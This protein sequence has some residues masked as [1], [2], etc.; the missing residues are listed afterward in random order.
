MKKIAVLAL[1]DVVPFDL[2]IPCGVFQFAYLK[3]GAPAYEV[4]VCGPKRSVRSKPFDLRIS[5]GLA[6]LRDADT[7]LVP[8]MFD[9]DVRFPPS[10][11]QA[12]R[13]AVRRGTRVASICSGAFVLAEAGVLNGLKATTHWI[14]A[15]D[16]AR[17]YPEIDVNP[18]VLYVDNGQILTSAGAASGLDLCLHLVRRDYGSAVAAN[19]A[20]YSVVPLERA[21]GQAQFIR[22]LEPASP[23][24][25]DELLAWMERNYRRPVQL[26]DLARKARMSPR[27]LLRRFQEQTGESPLQ[28][29]L[30]IRVCRGQELLE[31][32]KLSVEEV[33]ERVGFGCSLS[34]RQRFKRQV[35]VTPQVYRASF[36]KA[37]KA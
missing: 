33:A 17:R 13:E 4:V 32:T 16:L 19:A 22:N 27:T 9:V 1:D 20:R 26:E 29:L 24:A 14:G 28:W 36:A 34:F 23:G 7:I 31:S 18:N 5:H 11:L 10:V 12:I 8:G 2:A 30:R 35:G 6:A 15:A 25:L 3:N 21:G 37:V